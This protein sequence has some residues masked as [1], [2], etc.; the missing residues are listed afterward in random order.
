M[1]EPTN[2]SQVQASTV[3]SVIVVPIHME[4]LLPLYGQQ[5]GEDTFGETSSK[6]DDLDLV[7]LSVFIAHRASCGFT[8]VVFLIH[9]WSS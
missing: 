4:D 7:G 3:S 6:H 2:L 5:T 9:G 8:D 1:D